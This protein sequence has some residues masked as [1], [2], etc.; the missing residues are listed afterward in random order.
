VSRIQREQRDPQQLESRPNT[1]WTWR[2]LGATAP[3]A[4][5]EIHSHSF[6]HLKQYRLHPLPDSKLQTTPPPYH[7]WERVSWAEP[8]LRKSLPLTGWRWRSRSPPWHV[9]GT[10]RPLGS[11][12]LGETRCSHWCVAERAERAGLRLTHARQVI[13]FA[14]KC[15][16]A[17]ELGKV[18]K[19]DKILILCAGDPCSFRV[20]GRPAR[21]HEPDGPWS[22][23]TVDL[24]HSC[25]GTAQRPRMYPVKYLNIIKNDTKVLEF[26][27]TGRKGDTAQFQEQVRIVCVGVCM[28]GVA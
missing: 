7:T 18:G 14:N 26:I 24:A 15:G 10:S 9:V 23:T 27:P 2:K 8:D 20:T 16:Q 13:A 21:T 3:Q 4:K 12:V 19:K 11:C 28:C 22:M 6:I 1:W 17:V 5:P 25:D